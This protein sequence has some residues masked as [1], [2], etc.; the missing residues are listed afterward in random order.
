MD[1]LT[2]HYAKVWVIYTAIVVVAWFVPL[3]IPYLYPALLVGFVVLSVV[4][5]KL[6][7]LSIGSG[8]SEFLCDSCKFNYGDACKRTERPNATKCPDYQ[9]R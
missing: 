1:W 4:W 9:Q 2:R 5:F 3:E 7:G 6:S 8:K